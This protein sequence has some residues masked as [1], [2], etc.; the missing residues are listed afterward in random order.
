MQCLCLA[1]DFSEVWHQPCS[2]QLCPFILVLNRCDYMFRCDVWCQFTVRSDGRGEWREMCTAESNMGENGFL[3]GHHLALDAQTLAF[4][5]LGWGWW[6]LDG[7]AWAHTRD[8]GATCMSSN[9][10]VIKQTRKECG[11][12]EGNER[13]QGIRGG[14]ARVCSVVIRAG[15][16]WTRCVKMTKPGE[17]MFACGKVRVCLCICVLP[18]FPLSGTELL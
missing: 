14:R 15:C 4:A 7:P 10:I 11:E 1:H 3:A 9:L 2:G 6:A 8:F 18:V 16:E 12:G 13:A 17:A 5:C